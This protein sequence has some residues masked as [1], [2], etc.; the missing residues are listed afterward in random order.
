MQANVTKFSSSAGQN[1]NLNGA[2]AGSAGDNVAS[3]AASA[4]STSGIAAE[5][6]FSPNV[7]VDQQH[8]HQQQDSVAV[9]CGTPPTSAKFAQ[10][11][12]TSGMYVVDNL[13]Q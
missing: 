11:S 3:A 2:A 6:Q 9:A 1:Q 12:S 7:Q 8:H 13:S 4:S 10:S 5:R